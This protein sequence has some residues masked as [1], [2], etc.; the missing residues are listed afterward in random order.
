MTFDSCTQFLEAE[1]AKAR[2][3]ETVHSMTDNCWVSED[4]VEGREREG[5]LRSKRLISFVMW[6]RI[7]V[8]LKSTANWIVPKK[9]VLPTVLIDSWIPVC[10]LLSVWKI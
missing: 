1:Q 10:L 4:R 9:L 5:G 7:S 3:Q 6:I 8:S 2:V